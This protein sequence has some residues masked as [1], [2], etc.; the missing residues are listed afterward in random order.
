MFLPVPSLCCDTYTVFN[1][2]LLLHLLGFG[3]TVDLDAQVVSVLLPV[4]LA[5]RHVE[6]VAYTQLPTAWDLNQCHTCRG[7]GLLWYPVGNDVVGWGP[8]EVSAQSNKWP[9]QSSKV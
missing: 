8:A 3:I 9:L 2:V 4:H 6:Q 1:L 7:V 5:V